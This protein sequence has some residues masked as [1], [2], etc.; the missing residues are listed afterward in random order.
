MKQPKKPSY[1][2]K[3]VLSRKGLNPDEWM[4]QTENSN[5]IVIVNKNTGATQLVEVD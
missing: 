1:K 3:K 2:I 4:V 5:L